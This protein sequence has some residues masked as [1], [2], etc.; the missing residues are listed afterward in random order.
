MNAMPSPAQ[1]EFY[2]GVL[3]VEPTVEAPGVCPAAPKNSR[4][5]NGQRSPRQRASFRLSGFV[6]AF[7]IGVAA[8][9]AWQ[10]YGD[11]AREMIASLSPQLDWLAPQGEPA[12]QNTPDAIALAAPAAPS[13]DQQQ[14]NAISTDLE[15]VRQSIDRIAPDLAAGQEQM[16]RT[17]ERIAATQEQMARTV[18]QLTAGQEQVMREITELQTVEKY[19]LYKN[20]EPPPHAAAGQARS[21]ILRPSQAPTGR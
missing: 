13:F 19:F 21:S 10:T 9:A 3:P 7:C 1:S 5:P 4:S 14:L 12:T 15:A 2:A 16:A 17:I 20:S 11:A 6:I 18:G 8:T